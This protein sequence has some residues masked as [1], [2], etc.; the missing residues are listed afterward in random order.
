MDEGDPEDFHRKAKR[1]RL[2]QKLIIQKKFPKN[3]RTSSHIESTPLIDITN[4]QG[5]EQSTL[6]STNINE[7]LGIEQ[8]AA[9]QSHKSAIF[10]RKNSTSGMS[11]KP[12]T[13]QYNVGSSSIGQSKHNFQYLHTNKPI[14]KDQYIP[15]HPFP[16]NL[17]NYGRLSSSIS[18]IPD[19]V[20]SP[21]IVNV[22]AG[23]PNS[24]LPNHTPTFTLPGSRETQNQ[25][26]RRSKSTFHIHTPSFTQPVS[27]EKQKHNPKSSS[28]INN[29]GINL[30]NKFTMTDTNV[31][32]SSSTQNDVQMDNDSEGSADSEEFQA[33]NPAHQ[34]AS[35]SSEDEGESSNADQN[36]AQG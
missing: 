3:C 6:N 8:T 33:Y 35:E 32:S 1:A 30:I 7:R 19:Q 2:R 24:S 13:S 22:P 29:V 9:K 25:N 20:S 14:E 10:D 27:V 36:N 31:P 21:N 18:Q 34:S 5:K 4:T 16:I 26:P 17:P 23:M 15:K 28:R 12:L 11:Y